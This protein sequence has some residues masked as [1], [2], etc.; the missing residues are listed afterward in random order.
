VCFVQTAEHLSSSLLQT[1]VDW[2]LQFFSS[3]LCISAENVGSQPNFSRIFTNRDNSA[4]PNICRNYFPAIRNSK[5]NRIG[6]YSTRFNT[7]YLKFGSGFLSLAT[8]YVA[9]AAS[10]AS[11]H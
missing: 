4:K 9:E 2:Q 3:L 6:I 8:L 5:K 10:V 11:L 1:V 7:I